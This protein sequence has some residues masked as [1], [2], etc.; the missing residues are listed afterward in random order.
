MDRAFLPAR[1]IRHGDEPAPAVDFYT[2]SGKVSRHVK[3]SHAAQGP[4]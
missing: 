1:G 3:D 4:H 2:F